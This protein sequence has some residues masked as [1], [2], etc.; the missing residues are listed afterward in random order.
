MKTV[1]TLIIGAGPAGLAVG[2]ALTS[3]NHDVMLVDESPEV[4][5]RFRSHYKRL[6]LHTTRRWS[7]LPGVPI[8]RRF[9]QWVH[10][11]DF[12]DYLKMYSQYFGLHI[13][14]N[15]RVKTV[16][17]GEPFVVQTEQ[18]EIHAQNV[19]VATS[20]NS[21]PVLGPWPGTGDFAPPLLHSVQY[22][23]GRAHV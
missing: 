18:R 19:V 21:V 15:N 12:A 3:R 14:H 16:S 8:P 10:K 20:L 7:S 17:S 23:I 4:G 6:R 9:G 22:E 5:H 13:S 1:E 2:G 11:D